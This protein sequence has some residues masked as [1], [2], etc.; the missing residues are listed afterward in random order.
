MSRK[1]Y[2]VIIGMSGCYMPDTVHTYTSKRKAIAAAREEYKRA[3]DDY[4]DDSRHWK[5]VGVGNYRLC[6]HAGNTRQLYD[7]AYEI[8]ISGPCY[9]E[10][11]C[12][13]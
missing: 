8:R 2:H 3:N 5:Q 10:C 9:Q 4:G 6:E 13:A 1:H 12:D 7:L 11:M